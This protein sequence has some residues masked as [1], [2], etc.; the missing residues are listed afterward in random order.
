MGYNAA[1]HMDWGVFFVLEVAA[2]PLRSL[3]PPG[4]APVE[5]TP[6]QALLAVNLVHFLGGGD[7]VDLPQNHEIDIGVA[8]PVDNTA[9][10][11]LPQAASAAHVLNIVSTSEDYLEICRDSGYRVHGGQGLEFDI[12]PSGLDGRVRDGEG[13]ILSFAARG[14]DHAFQPFSRV[15]QDVIHDHRGEFRLNFVLE[16]EGAAAAAP[17]MF[18]LTL[19]DHPFFLGLDLDGESPRQLETFALRP[20]GKATMS[21]YV[22]DEG[23]T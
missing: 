4:I 14:R 3:L 18:D 13:A 12:A 5:R 16:G 19:H 8:V 7:Q 11:G 23:L 22:P 1:I 9:Y 15:G 10:T 17:E 6:G 21:F 20:G 2:A